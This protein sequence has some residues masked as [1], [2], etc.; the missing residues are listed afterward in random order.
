MMRGNKENEFLRL[1]SRGELLTV[2]ALDGKDDLAPHDGL[3]CKFVY[4]PHDFYTIDVPKQD[5]WRRNPHVEPCQ[6]TKET[7]V[8]V[9]RLIKDATFSQLFSSLSSDLHRVCFFSRAQVKNFVKKH[10]KWLGEGLSS[11][12][13][14]YRSDGDFFV[15]NVCI[16]SCFTLC[17][18]IHHFKNSS[19]WPSEFAI[20]VVTPKF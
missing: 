13:F 8:K 10:K 14:L 2:D 15:A 6:P 5:D 1:I 11:T 12:L 9:Y 7:E 20:R 17:L 18:Y 19:I 4:P 3:F 16:E